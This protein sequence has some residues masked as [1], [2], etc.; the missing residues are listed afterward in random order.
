M[1]Y[2]LLFL[3]LTYRLYSR[4]KAKEL[5][6]VEEYSKQMEGIFS[7]CINDSTLDEA[8]FA[9]RDMPS[10]KEAIQDTVTIEKILKPIYNFK[11]A[12]N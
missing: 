10:I 8:P 6:S 11:A 12:S 9:Y 3:I 7:T 5:F 2:R 1:L 4:S